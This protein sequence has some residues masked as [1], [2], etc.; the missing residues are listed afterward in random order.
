MQFNARFF[1]GESLEPK[2]V[3]LGFDEDRLV[4]TDDAGHRVSAH[5]KPEVT[6]L[7]ADQL[8]NRVDLGVTGLKDYRLMVE[9]PGVKQ[10]LL[11]YLPQVGQPLPDD[12]WGAGLKISAFLLAFVVF[13]GVIVWQIEKILP[14]LVPTSYAESFGR[15]IA[16][17]YIEEY[18]GVCSASDGMRA[19]DAMVTR[20]Q[21]NAAESRLTVR[22][23]D[24]DTVNAF[25]VPGRQI[26]IFRGL[27]DKAES[28]DEVAGVL[29]HEMGHVKHKHA[30]RG[31]TRTIGVS[32][33]ASIMSGSDASQI[34]QQLVVLGFS[35]SMEEEADA[36][37]LKTL[38]TAGV[39]HEAFARF[40]DRMAAENEGAD[41]AFMSFLSTHPSSGERADQIRSVR[42]ARE[43][44]PVISADEWQALKTICGSGE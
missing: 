32:V 1:N 42:R 23:A 26:V 2:H 11:R 15:A 3:V 28:A 34:V 19:L 27:F 16:D 9:A 6:L 5:P 21:P 37:A 41:P 14:A 22:V 43:T 40:F 33:L 17:E 12:S 39:D 13:L 44:S 8:G 38:S 36:E 29:A 4:I 18:G 20:L 10:D 31:L 35:R 30:L 7:F 24:S 25:A